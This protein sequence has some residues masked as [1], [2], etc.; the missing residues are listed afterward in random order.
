[1]K[2]EVPE[3]NLRTE[4]LTLSP[5]ALADFDE[6]AEMWA[7]EGVVRYMTGVPSAPAESWARLLR[8]AG[9]WFLLGYGFWVVREQGSNRFVGE[10]GFGDFHRSFSPEFSASPEAGWVLASWA[11]GRGYASEAVVAALA[12]A[13]LHLTAEATVCG[14]DVE[15]AAS[16]R[17]A[18]R[19]G[20]TNF[21]RDVH[22]GR[23][24]CLLR[25]PRSPSG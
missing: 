4:R 25:R 15:N 10:V 9:N 7:D 3:R 20:F 24:V 23:Q 16:L 21:G 12:W 19:C 2:Q 6:S 11:H 14:V 1:M 8:H 13:D 5:H 17:L 22:L 18:A